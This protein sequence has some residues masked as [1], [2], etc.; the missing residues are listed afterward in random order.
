MNIGILK[1]VAWLEMI[2]ATVLVAFALWPFSGFCAGRV[3]AFDCES[4]AILGVNMF[5]PAGI[6]I[7]ISAIWTLKSQSLKPQYFLLLGV[8]VIAIYWLSYML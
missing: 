6:L 1:A 3:M 4:R 7:F 8:G 5:G 2:L